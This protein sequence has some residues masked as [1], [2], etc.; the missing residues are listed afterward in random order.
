MAIVA[1]A[2]LVPM[3]NIL[4]LSF[5]DSNEVAKGIVNLWPV[6]FN[7]DSY[8]VI[9]K[10]KAFVRSFIVSLIRVMSGTSINVVLTVIMAYPLSKTARVMPGRN[11]FM[12]MMIFAMLF[13]GGLVPT[14]MLI[15]SLGLLNNYLV[16]ILPA[17]LPLFNVILIMNFIRMLPK[18]CEE[19][20]IIDGANYWQVLLKV[21]APLCMPSIATITLFSIVGH[22]NEYFT[23]IIYLDI[24]KYPLQTYL[25][26]MNVNRDINNLEQALLFRRVS[27]K[28]LLSAQIFVAMI[29]ILIFYPSLQRY[30]VKGI[31]L[32][33]V[34]G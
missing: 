26:T 28:T 27:D 11:V 29:P 12:W 21:I 6:G 20:A 33:A 10:E 32:G 16:L 3:I 9:L 34:K 4:A 8:T 15:K 22:W 14:Y 1:F 2:C 30:F 18:F 23:G 31:V 19:A 17:A 5:S 7:F 24:G 25:F 13:N